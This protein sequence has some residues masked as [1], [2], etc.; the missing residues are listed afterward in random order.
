M[1]TVYCH[2][3]YTVQNMSKG[4]LYFILYK[5]PLLFITDKFIIDKWD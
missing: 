5:Q 4:K 2:K 3:M 1:V